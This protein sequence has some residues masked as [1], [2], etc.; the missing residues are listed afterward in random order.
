MVLGVMLGPASILLAAKPN[1]TEANTLSMLAVNPQA[2]SL[3][4]ARYV[5]QHSR[6]FRHRFK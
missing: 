5:A 2:Q 4:E 6:L 1:T 3:L